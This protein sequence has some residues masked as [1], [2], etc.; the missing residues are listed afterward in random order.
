MFVT[1]SFPGGAGHPDLGTLVWDE[2][3]VL[4]VPDEFGAELLDIPGAGFSEVAPQDAPASK[5]RAKKTP[6]A[7]TTAPDES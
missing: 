2:G 7:E 3:T 4:E 5:G 1:K 6:V